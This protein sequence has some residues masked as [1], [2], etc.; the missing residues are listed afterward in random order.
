MIKPKWTLDDLL[1]RYGLDSSVPDRIIANVVLR[2]GSRDV[3]S[4]GELADA[5]LDSR[6]YEAAIRFIVACNAYPSNGNEKLYQRVAEIVE[7]GGPEAES[8]LLALAKD[9]NG[10]YFVKGMVDMNVRDE[11]VARIL[12]GAGLENVVDKWLE[13]AQ[14]ELDY[15]HKRRKD[16]DIYETVSD[17][18]FY[19]STGIER[20]AVAEMA[21]KRIEDVKNALKNV[22]PSV[23]PPPPKTAP[24]GP[25][26]K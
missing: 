18:Y 17:G 21:L 25:G 23:P 1:Y 15:A 4:L 9:E 8:F 2:V 19:M 26:M 24:R 16:G 14:I 3:Y 11:T 10:G 20:V 5:C 13:R 12:K 7:G 22:P 6:R